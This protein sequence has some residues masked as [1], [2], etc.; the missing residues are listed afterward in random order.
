VS[1]AAGPWALPWI[2]CFAVWLMLCPAAF[3]VHRLAAGRL[4]T[5]PAAPR[6]ALLLALAVLPVTVAALVAVL[7]F[8]RSLGGIVVDHHCHADT[9]CGAHVPILHAGA[10]YALTVGALLFVTTLVLCGGILRR[11]QRTQRVASALGVLAEP[12]PL[13]RCE[14]VDSPEPFAYCIGLWRPKVVISTGLERALS[15]EELGAVVAHEHAHAARRD[16]LRHGLAALALLPLGPRLRRALLADL[17]LASEQ[18]C[19]RAALG[20]TGDAAALLGAFATMRPDGHALA[21]RTTGFGGSVMLARRVAS[22]ERGRVEAHAPY[23]VPATVIGVYTV[24]ALATTYVAH[25]GTEL[26]LGWLG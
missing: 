9:G 12:A 3:A 17:T 16:N 5:V 10:P 13:A 20:P 18:A 8:T 26:L 23:A 2:A 14:I 4:A 15:S 6:S 19:D 11:L 24:A 1:A 21:A 25:H 22:L 7:G